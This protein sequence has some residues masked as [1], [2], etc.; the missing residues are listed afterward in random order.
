MV[1][2]TRD[3][4]GD[5]MVERVGGGAGV[6]QFHLPTGRRMNDQELD[7]LIAHVQTSGTDLEC[8]MLIQMCEILT[9]S[10]S[11]ARDWRQAEGVIQDMR[12]AFIKMRGLLASVTAKTKK[13]AVI[14]IM[15][16][17]LDEIDVFEVAEANDG[18]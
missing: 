13:S 5:E 16:Q 11:V 12:T 3:E 4:L 9:T 15:Q 6:N 14:E 10:V 18:V 1:R 2:I 17:V 8:E 7:A